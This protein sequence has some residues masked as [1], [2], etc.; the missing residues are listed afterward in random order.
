MSFSVL[1][2]FVAALAVM[3]LLAESY[4]FVR[5]RF[6]GALLAPSVLGILFGILAVVQM[7]NPIEPFEGLIIDMRAVPVALAGAFLGWRGVLPCV[8]IALL[9]RWEL[10]GVGMLAGWISI[11][12]AALAGII[13]ARKT[14]HLGDRGFPILLGLALAM[15]SHL[16]GALALP[17]DLAAWF[18]MNAGLPILA[19]NLVAVPTL[20]ALME[21]ENRRIRIMDEM[22]A[23]ATRDPETGL[24]TGPAFARD[25]TNAFA[26]HSLGTYAGLLAIEPRFDAFNA[27]LAR[28]GL[29]THRHGINRHGLESFL[30]QA[31]LAGQTEGGRVLI[32]LTQDEMLV[33]P[34]LVDDIRHDLQ[35]RSRDTG[36]AAMR[37]HVTAVPLS[38]PAMFLRVIENEANA[39]DAPWYQM[40]RAEMSPLRPGQ[41]SALRRGRLFSPAEHDA[42]FRK[43]DF[44]MDRRKI[45]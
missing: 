9:G 38:D 33:A 5:R 40:R 39:E 36:G 22:Q 31:N 32:P 23:A 17:S 27:V 35:D 28:A 1:M 24:L 34:Q 7:H 41:K 8:A 44:L 29:K 14:A 45:N 11:V 16:L 13:W 20:A 2:D 15:S 10:G 4:G 30:S 25:V 12:I 3:A 26:A 42:L 37:Y 6:V 18:L 21:R 43:A 19:A